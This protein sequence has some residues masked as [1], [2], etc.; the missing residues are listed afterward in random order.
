MTPIVLAAYIAMI[1]VWGTT[2]AAI[3]I[4]VETVPPFVFALERAIAVAAVLTVVALALR[5]PF[6]RDRVTLLAAAIAG[7]FNTGLSWALIFWAEQFVPSGLVAVFGA[8]APVWTAFLAHFL[9]RGDRLSWLKI[10]ALGLGLAGTAVL[11]GSPVTRDG[12]DV[13]AVTVLLALMP[14]TWAIASILASRYLQHA[15]PVPVIAVEVWAGAVVLVP[16]ALT[17]A[18]LPSVWTAPAVVS[19]AYLVLL[20]SC[21]GLVLNLW[22]YRKLRPT[23][24]SLAQVLIP[25]Q[26]VLI[27]ALALGEQVT[28]RTL[29]GA[30]L[31]FTAVGLNARAGSGRPDLRATEPVATSAD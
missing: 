3:K 25:V 14:V 21:V 22:L 30:V 7:I 13:V 16:F 2:W 11:V 19:F 23:T 29:V 28:T 10:A 12:A 20:G 15:S 9:V 5:L 31:V 8:T 6:P 24:V 1:L 18:A 26:A 17:Q 4:G 27:G